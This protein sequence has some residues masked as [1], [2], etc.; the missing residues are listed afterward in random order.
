MTTSQCLFPAIE[1]K[2]E[3]RQCRAKPHREEEQ[4]GRGDKRVEATAAAVAVVP[5]AGVEY[6]MLLSRSGRQVR[7]VTVRQLFSHA[8]VSRCTVLVQC[9]RQYQRQ[10]QMLSVMSCVSE[11]A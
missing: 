5:P 1:G 4:V 11:P 7:S 3:K 2:Q 8:A 6:T 9:Q 10:R